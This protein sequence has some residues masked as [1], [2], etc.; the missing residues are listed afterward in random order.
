M[1]NKRYALWIYE[2]D[3]SPTEER[4][5]MRKTT[6]TKRF[7]QT[8]ILSNKTQKSIECILKEWNI[9]K[10]RWETHYRLFMI[11]NEE[12]PKNMRI[13]ECKHTPIFDN[14]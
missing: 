8:L 11:M 9:C 1:G 14:K 7:F 12:D 13:V 5:V 10:Q 2:D 4:F 6:D 3:M